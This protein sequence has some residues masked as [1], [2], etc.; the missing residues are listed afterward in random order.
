[1]NDLEPIKRK[2]YEIRGYRIML[3]QTL[4]TCTTLKQKT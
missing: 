3:D 4:Q 2:I 1:M